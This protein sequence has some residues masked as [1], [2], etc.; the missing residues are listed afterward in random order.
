MSSLTTTA[1]NALFTALQSKL[2]ASMK[3]AIIEM[4]P[5]EKYNELTEACFDEFLNGPR[6]YRFETIEVY[7]SADDPR[8]TTGKSG[9]VRITTE[10][11]HPMKKNE[12]YIIN[13]DPNTLPGMVMQILREEA[14]KMTKEAIKKWQENNRSTVTDGSDRAGPYS[15]SQ[16]MLNDAIVNFCNANA[17]RIFATMLSGVVNQAMSMHLSQGHNGGYRGY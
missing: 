8:N 3:A 1:D 6:A 9:N 12:K 13:D 15:F 7:L 10:L 14:T 2:N 5:E 17:G 16:A 11:F 4:I